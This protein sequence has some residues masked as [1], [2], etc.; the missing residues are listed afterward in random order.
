MTR[1]V[2]PATVRREEILDCAQRL[3]SRQ[4]Y[5]A[6]SVNQIIVTLGLSK[7]AFYHHFSAKADLIEA[8]A[9]R[10]ADDAA[11]MAQPVLDDESLDAFSRLSKFLA[12]MRDSKVNA[13]FEV[14]N[15][16][17]PLF[18]PENAALY[19]RV[20]E[21]LFGVVRPTLTRIIAEGVAE[22]TFDTSNAELAADTILGLMGSTRR[23]VTDL[24]AARNAADFDRAACDLVER[25]RYLGTVVDRILGLPEGSI[26]LS[27]P[28]TIRFMIDTWRR[29]ETAA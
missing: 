10:F 25:Y 18:R 24:Y 8:L 9:L 12:S 29:E 5:D 21:A 19:E 20:E 14:R 15:T 6:T 3:F 2:K 13:A 28:Q 16:F 26:V 7:G 23:A 27:D 11:R 4:G 1:I 17:E 22:Q